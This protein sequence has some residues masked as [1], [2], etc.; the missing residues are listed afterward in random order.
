MHV[1]YVLRYEEWCNHC[2]DLTNFPNVYVDADSGTE[3]LEENVD[4]NDLQ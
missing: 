4:K 2:C 3:K 1:P